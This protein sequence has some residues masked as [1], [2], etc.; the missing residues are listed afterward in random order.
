MQ[1]SQTLKRKPRQSRIWALMV[2]QVG[3]ATLELEEIGQGIYIK[4]DVAMETD[5]WQ[6][7]AAF[8]VEVADE[9]FIQFDR[10]ETPNDLEDLMRAWASED[11][12]ASLQL[13]RNEFGF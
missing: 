7:T 6:G 3:P 13:F 12:W 9:A 11:T 8:P 5:V 4:A 10:I 1:G 2:K